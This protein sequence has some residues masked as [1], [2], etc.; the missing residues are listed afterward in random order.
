M[1]KRGR[2]WRCWGRNPGWGRD[3]SNE[4]GRTLRAR[5]GP[6]MEGG[7]VGYKMNAVELRGIGLGELRRKRGDGAG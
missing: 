6:E 3:G 7:G 4:V 5:Y 2:G 1:E